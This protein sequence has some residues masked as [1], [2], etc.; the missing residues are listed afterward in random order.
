M[1]YMKVSV[2]ILLMALMLGCSQQPTQTT[3]NF[4]YKVIKHSEEKDVLAREIAKISENNTFPS[5][6][7][8]LKESLA[9]PDSF[10]LV[11]VDY[12][13][14]ENYTKRPASTHINYYYLIRIHFTGSNALDKQCTSYQDYE[15]YPDGEI[16]VA[17]RGEM[18]VLGQN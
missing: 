5:L 11:R 2:V 9:K 6:V 15:L 7:E 12:G 4:E 8:T 16:E 14:R 17:E 18:K 1:R 10:K 3:G 13:I